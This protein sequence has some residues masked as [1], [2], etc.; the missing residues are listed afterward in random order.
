MESKTKNRQSR[1]TLGQ[2]VNRAFGI[3]LADADD[4]VCELKDGWFNAAYILRL[5]DR[6]EVILKI[7][8]PVDA[9]VMTY[10]KG[11]MLTEVN[12]MRHVA[13]NPAIPVS[14]IY[15]FDDSREVCDSEYFFM[16][17]LAGE[18]MHHAR[19]GLPPGT[20]VRIEEHI[21]RIVRE[22]NTYTGTYFGY[23]GNPDLRGT[24]WRE[25]FLKIIDAV[26]DDGVRK[27]A[28][29]GYTVEEI[30]AA[31]VKHGAALDEITAPVLVHWDVWNPNVLVRDGEIT[32]I[33]D[34][35]RAL[36]GDP[37]MESQFREP[38]YKGGI[39]DSMRGYGKTTFTRA[40][41]A[42]CHMYT[43]YLALVMETEGH[44]RD[45]DSDEA[46][47]FARMVMGPAMA[48]LQEN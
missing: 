14:E 32:G 29:F 18:S 37:L 23:E 34:F 2:M 38:T 46:S 9:E 11:L 21:G 45:Y 10:E 27:N 4:A 6:R 20:V 43:I 39:S 12:A 22:I 33:I 8:P 44:Y 17:K 15:Y 19:A 3:G 24:G 41:E 47:S 35:E 36:W 16:E 7:A 42:R 25:T 28:D 48:W 5:A 26:I 13:A 31:I 40:E 1:A 30:R